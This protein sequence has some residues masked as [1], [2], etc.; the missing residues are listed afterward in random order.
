MGDSV[1]CRMV[2]SVKDDAMFELIAGD[3]EI[4]RVFG[5]G[6]EVVNIITGD[7]VCNGSA[8]IPYEEFVTMAATIVAIHEHSDPA[9]Q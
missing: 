4:G 6:H 9:T 2:N 1:L 7:S 5:N 8:W 3:S